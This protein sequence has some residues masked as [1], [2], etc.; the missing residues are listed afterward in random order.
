MSFEK[1][2]KRES[3]VSESKVQKNLETGQFELVSADGEVISYATFTETD[4]LVTIPLVFTPPEHRGA[5]HASALMAG[6][7]RRTQAD[8]QQ[9]NP[10]CPYAAAY[11]TRHA[12]GRS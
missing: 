12:E 6:I 4:D 8:D 5:G 9:I 11:L 10:V 3:V 1:S 7:L 2:T